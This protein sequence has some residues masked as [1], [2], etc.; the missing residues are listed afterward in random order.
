MK[1]V[2]FVEILIGLGTYPSN[3]IQQRLGVRL[4]VE[5]EMGLLGREIYVPINESSMY[6]SIQTENIVFFFF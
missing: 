5:L 1:V 3:K 6:I 4:E 2:D